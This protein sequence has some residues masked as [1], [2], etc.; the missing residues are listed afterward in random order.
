[1]HEHVQKSSQKVFI[2]GHQILTALKMYISHKQKLVKGIC[3]NL[4]KE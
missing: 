1:M 3:K 4:Y 2:G